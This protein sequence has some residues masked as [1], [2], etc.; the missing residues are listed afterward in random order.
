MTADPRA[1][2]FTAH[3]GVDYSGAST[4]RRRLRGLRVYESRVMGEPREIRPTPHPSWHWTRRDLAEWLVQ[5]LRADT[6]TIVGIDHAFSFPRHW[7][8]VHS[9]PA[10]WLAFLE[11]F[12]RH[13]RTDDDVARVMD[14]RRRLHGTDVAREGNA[15]WLRATEDAAS[16]E[17]GGPRPKSVF[18]FD[19]PGQVA[20]STCAGLPWLLFLRRALGD[21]VHIWP[22]D[23]W[24]PPAGKSVVAEV[25][26]SL[27]NREPARAERTPDQH[28]AYCVAKALQAA[29][30][31]GSLS[32]W[33]QPELPDPVRRD[34]AI[35]GWILGVG[36]SRSA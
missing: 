22:F 23:G 14:A 34:A 10:D 5:R 16:R 28:D 18:H 8:D 32:R 25:Y 15:R 19:V 3:I 7:F 30:L 2:A 35:E 13:W 17:Q 9:V 33:L 27:W 1:A 12:Q 24:L 20:K 31:D 11:D 26:P 21:R 29:D 6:P 4:P 36:A